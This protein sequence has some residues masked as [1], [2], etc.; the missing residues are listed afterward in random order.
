LHQFAT[1]TRDGGN[2]AIAGAKYLPDIPWQVVK[3]ALM[4]IR[5]VR[6]SIG[7]GQELENDI[8]PMIYPSK[9][10]NAAMVNRYPARCKKDHMFLQPSIPRVHTKLVLVSSRVSFNMNDM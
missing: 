9:R 7:S 4:V 8:N 2:A 3:Y 5:T 10:L 6:I 1:V